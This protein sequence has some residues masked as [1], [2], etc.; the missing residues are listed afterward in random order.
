VKKKI[1]GSMMLMIINSIAAE[2]DASDESSTDAYDEQIIR[3]LTY[4][5]SDVDPNQ[6]SQVT[7]ITCDTVGAVLGAGALIGGI[8]LAHKSYNTTQHW[9]QSPPIYLLAGTGAA[10]SVATELTYQA[11]FES[12]MHPIVLF[13]AKALVGAVEGA[14]V[15][16]VAAGSGNSLAKNA[17]NSDDKS[18]LSSTRSW[19]SAGLTTALGASIGIDVIGK[20]AKNTWKKHKK[21]SDDK[22]ISA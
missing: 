3:L 22:E 12:Q 21:T 2:G 20:M 10:L 17:Q 14:I 8:Y 19:I 7:S 4:P 5:S 1:I 16:A 13:G 18:W 15:G 9:W 6:I 11:P